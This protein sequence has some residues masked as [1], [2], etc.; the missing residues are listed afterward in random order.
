MTLKELLKNKDYQFFDNIP[1]L[2]YITKFAEEAPH[3]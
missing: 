2:A 3:L 1:N